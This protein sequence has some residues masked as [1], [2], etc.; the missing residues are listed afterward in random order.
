MDFWIHGDGG[1][2][3]AP[4]TSRSISAVVRPPCAANEA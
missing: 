1:I 3:N 4:A 2:E